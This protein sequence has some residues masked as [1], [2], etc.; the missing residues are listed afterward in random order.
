MTQA[1]AAAPDKNMTTRWF[2][3]IAL[4]VAMMAVANPQYAWTL[5]TT[6][7][8]KDFNAS[9]AAVQLALTLFIAVQT[10]LVPVETYLVD[11][12]GPRW[13]MTAGGAILALSW[14]MTSQVQSLSVF[15]LTYAIGGIGVGTIYGASIGMAAKWFPDRRGLAAGMVAGSYGFGTL[16]TVLPIQNSL[17]ANGWRQTFLVAGLVMGVVIIIASQFVRAPELGWKPAGWVPKT[18]GKGLLQNTRNYTPGQMMKTAPFYVLYLMMTMVAFGGMMVTAQLK[19]IG[20]SYG[21]DKYMVLGMSAVSLALMLDR[22][23][24]GF[25]RPMWGYISDR[26]GRYNTMALAFGLEAIMIS[27]FAYMIKSPIAFIIMSGMTFFAWGEIYSLF[28]SAITDVY[29]SKYASSNYGIQY[30]S[31]GVATLLAG[32]GAALLME[33]AGSWL[34]VFYCAVAMDAIA[35]VLAFFWLKPMVARL[36]AEGNSQAKSAAS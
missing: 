23:L 1:T 10:W 29:G 31:K 18:S 25:T 16:F 9:L 21:Y 33:W 24:N 30:T 19:P 5:F 13:I 4:V 26:I 35:A 34:P 22:A 27:I 6:D 2:I 36:I 14:W 11:R 28:P 3:L 12:F 8:R 15:Y 7:L 20:V 17:D 32:P